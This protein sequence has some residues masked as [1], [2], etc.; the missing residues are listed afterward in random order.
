MD[1]VEQMGRMGGVQSDGRDD[2]VAHGEGAG[3]YPWCLP[4][5]L[6]GFIRVRVQGRVRRRVV[7]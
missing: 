5:F 6:V 3:I 7:N 1:P 2:V 4:G